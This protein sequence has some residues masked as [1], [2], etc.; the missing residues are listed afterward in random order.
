MQV[1][2]GGILIPAGWKG[3]WTARIPGNEELQ[4]NGG[5]ESFAAFCH[6]L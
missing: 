5:R 3:L 2:Q 6:S 1:V 4:L